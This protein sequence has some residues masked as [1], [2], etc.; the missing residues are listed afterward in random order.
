M[1]VR[2][3]RSRIF[4]GNTLL[5]T[6]WKTNH[7]YSRHSIFK[8]ATHENRGV[9]APRPC[10]TCVQSSKRMLNLQA[11]M[12][13]AAAVLSRQIVFKNTH[14]TASIQLLA[15][16]MHPN[17]HSYLTLLDDEGLWQQQ[18]YAGVGN[19]GGVGEGGPGASCVTLTPG[20]LSFYYRNCLLCTVLTTRDTCA[21]GWCYIHGCVGRAET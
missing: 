3:L 12:S 5:T 17:H 10:T 11:W 1:C 8:R 6:S 9:S 13:D 21:Y 14:C 19:A 2:N 4:P 20:T 16:N 15:I 7:G 18:L